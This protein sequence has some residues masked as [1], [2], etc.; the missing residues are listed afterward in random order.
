MSVEDGTPSSC[1]RCWYHYAGI[2]K[3]ARLFR[4]PQNS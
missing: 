3:A 2:K 1:C 4:K